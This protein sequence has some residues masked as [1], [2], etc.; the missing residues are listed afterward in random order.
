MSH[1]QGDVSPAEGKQELA[2][3]WI[4]SSLLS[5]HSAC[6]H[7]RPRAEFCP[8]A[9]SIMKLCVLNP[10]QVSS[11]LTTVPELF[12]ALPPQ[13]P[14][15]PVRVEGVLGRH[16]PPHDSVQEGLALAGIE[17]ENLQGTEV[18]RPQKQW[19]LRASQLLQVR[20][21]TDAGEQHEPDQ[22]GQR[23]TLASTDTHLNIPPNSCQQRRERFV[24]VTLQLSP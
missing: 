4:T 20:A 23:H 15:Q 24:P 16:A 22:T 7:Q 9:H 11:C 21:R 14:H 1:E 10:P 18:G 8:R 6:F 2:L 3:A 17:P 5:T 19:H 13:I 12:L